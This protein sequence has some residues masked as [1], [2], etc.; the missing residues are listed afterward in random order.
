MS[1]NDHI[2]WRMYGCCCDIYVHVQ[3]HVGNHDVVV[4]SLYV[5]KLQTKEKHPLGCNVSHVEKSRELLKWCPRHDRG[6]R[7]TGMTQRVLPGMFIRE[8]V[9]T[10]TGTIRYAGK[11]PYIRDA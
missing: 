10:G 9:T 5:R 2:E 6:M 1:V 3:R 7:F 11:D 8:P 4:R